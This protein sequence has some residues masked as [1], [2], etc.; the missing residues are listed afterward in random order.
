MN[1]GAKADTFW[2]IIRA[3]NFA[4]SEPE[5]FTIPIQRNKKEIHINIKIFGTQ[6]CFDT[7]K[8]ERFFKERNVKYQYV[9]LYRYGLSKGEFESVKNAVGLRELINSNA[10]EYKTLNMQQLGV[11]SVAAEVLYKTQGS[12][13]HPSQE[14]KAGNRW[15]QTGS[16]EGLG[17]EG[18]KPQHHGLQYE[19]REASVI[20]GRYVICFYFFRM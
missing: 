20:I 10:K 13:K 3:R 6:K 18:A 14:W 4:C 8:A 11:G 7:K 2:R 19:R 1:E 15:L 17:V 12:I 9:D 5:N 16:L